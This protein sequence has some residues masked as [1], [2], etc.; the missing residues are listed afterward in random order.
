MKTLACTLALAFL[1][2]G[3]TALA[4]P[5][6]GAGRAENETPRTVYGEG[7]FTDDLVRGDLTRPDLAVAWGRTRRPLPSLLTIRQHFVPEM[8]KSV[9]KQ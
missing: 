4:Q 5:R 7:T 3:S 2:A 8:L 1:L 9:E 6:G